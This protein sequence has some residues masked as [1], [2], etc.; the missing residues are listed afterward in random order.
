MDYHMAERHALKFALLSTQ[1]QQR[2]MKK[3]AQQA[4]NW[5]RQNKMNEDP[6]EAIAY[7]WQRRVRLSREARAIHLVRCFMK[8][9]PYKKVEQHNRPFHTMSPVI[10]V[11]DY[12]PFSKVMESSEFDNKFRAWVEAA[13]A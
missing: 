12:M 1:Q 8:G 10:V 13:A 4:R 5:A 2:I 11:V 6:V 3:L 9:V 7:D